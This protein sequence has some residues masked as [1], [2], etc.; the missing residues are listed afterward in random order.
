MIGYRHIKGGY[1]RM[2]E[3][4]REREEGRT[5]NGNLILFSALFPLNG[6]VLK[7]RESL[8][9]PRRNTLGFVPTWFP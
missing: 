1:L 6:A 9:A 5:V 4:E 7:R 8:V 2:G 3:R